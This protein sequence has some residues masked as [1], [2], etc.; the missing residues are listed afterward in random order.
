MPR[1]GH[2]LVGVHE[3][4]KIPSPRSGKFTHPRGVVLGVLGSIVG[5]YRDKTYSPSGEIPGTLPYRL[6]D[7]EHVGAVVAGEKDHRGSP[8]REILQTKDFVGRIRQGE[9]GNFFPQRQTLC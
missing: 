3:V 1:F 9:I 2:T 7:M 6:T 4:R 8:D 5:I